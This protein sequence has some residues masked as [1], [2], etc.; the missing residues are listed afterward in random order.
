MSRP[1]Q[2]QTD[3]QTWF[4]EASCLRLVKVDLED[5]EHVKM[6]DSQVRGGGHSHQGRVSAAAQ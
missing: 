2:S 5:N 3:G 1:I 6:Y 4:G